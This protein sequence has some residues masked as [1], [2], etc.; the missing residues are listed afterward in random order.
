MIDLFKRYQVGLKLEDIYPLNKDGF[1]DCG[2][3]KKLEGKKKRWATVDCQDKVVINF[4]IIKGD[5]AVIRQSVF[6][7]DLGYCRGCGVLTEN[8]EVD[9]IIPVFLGGS[10]CGLENLQ[11]L[12]VDCHKD[13]TYTESHL[14]TISS[15]AACILDN[16]RAIAFGAVSCEFPK[17]SI[18][19]QRFTSAD[20]SFS[21]K[22]ASVY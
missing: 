11:T 19:M 16:R 18:D 17:Q 15:H 22:L 10:A 12:C 4:W 7:M 1:C 20:C 13:K 21:N 3:G 5:S 14:N 6:Q 9:H 2:C 8:W